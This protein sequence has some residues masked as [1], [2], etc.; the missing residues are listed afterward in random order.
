MRYV[1]LLTLLLLPLN[2][3]TIHAQ[4]CP[5][6][7][8]AVGVLSTPGAVSGIAIDGSY[9]Y[10]GGTPGIY[11]VDLSAPL[12]PQVVATWDELPYSARSG[13]IVHDGTAYAGLFDFGL[14]ALDVSNPLAPVLG[15]T[16]R[17]GDGV[18]GMAV[19]ENLLYMASWDDGVL[20]FDITDPGDLGIVD[21]LDVSGPAGDV[22]IDG[23]R[24]YVSE[25]NE[26]LDIYDLAIPSS[27]DLLGQF[28]VN[29]SYLDVDGPYA[30]LDVDRHMAIV[31]V[32]NPAAP[33]VVGETEGRRLGYKD[34]VVNDGLVF[35]TWGDET[36]A[37]DVFEVS[38][39]SSPRL[40]ARVRKPDVY[41]SGVAVRESVA[42]VTALEDGLVVVDASR[43]ETPVLM[44]SWQAPVGSLV[45]PGTEHGQ[46]FDFAVRDDRALVLYQP[47]DL[48][49]LQPGPYSES[50]AVLDISNTEEPQTLATINLWADTL[51]SAGH[52]ISQ[53]GWLG[54]LA[55]VAASSELLVIDLEAPEPPALVGQVSLP[56]PIYAMTVRADTAYVTGAAGFGIVDLSTAA[57]PVTVGTYSDDAWTGFCDSPVDVQVRGSRAFVTS[58]STFHIMDISDPAAPSPVGQGVYDP[59]ENQYDCAGF[60]MPDVMPEIAMK[61]GY[62][63]VPLHQVW[64]ITD[65]TMPV[66]VRSREG[67]ASAACF[68]QGDLLLIANLDGGLS[69]ENVRDSSTPVRIGA[70]VV[71]GTAYNARA[72][73]GRWYVAAGY[74]GFQIYESMCAEYTPVGV[75]FL[76]AVRDGLEAKLTWQVDSGSQAFFHVYREAAYGGQRVRLTDAPLSGTGW[77][78]LRD[79]SPPQG[80]TV[81]WLE[82]LTRAGGSEWY[83]PAVLPATERP[84]IRLL[85]CMPSP[86]TAE[87][88]VEFDIPKASPVSLLVF[89]VSGRVVATLADQSMPPGRHGVTWNGFSDRGAPVPGGIYFVRLVAAGQSDTRKLIRIPR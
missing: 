88:R 74:G 50:A 24:L 70:L 41:S 3:A 53:V 82:E 52:D 38:D 51:T 55:V 34:I 44:G 39:P 42:Y 85:P 75:M 9:A 5:S 71:P 43:R 49:V 40:V 29:V 11:V 62:L 8:F 78:T 1:L 80:E 79:P 47:D 60:A 67:E 15:D 84:A 22:C 18:R 48:N 28:D 27:P 20:I 31:D 73:D 72:V 7:P 10:L 19:Y 13:L 6:G 12:S 68:V 32:S 89:D 56:F 65:E 63:Y 4:N 81:Y 69:L 83:G 86:F 66:Q 58:R 33:V 23:G 57:H 35:T 17:L 61:D 64:D 37:A 16:V 59:G 87:V 2:A 14:V 54:P 76:S 25:Y 36:V 30:Y 21:T 77:F 46:V 26:R 45:P